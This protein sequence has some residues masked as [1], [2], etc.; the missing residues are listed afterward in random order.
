MAV[1][2]RLPAQLVR[3]DPPW[4]NFA[5]TIG[6]L[7]DLLVAAKAV[8]PA[9]A[10]QAVAAVLGREAEGSTALLDIRIGI[11]HGR[12]A[13]LSHSLLALAISPAG[14][15]EAVP[16]V[17]IQIV[18]L[19]LSPPAATDEHLETLAEIATLLR[20]DDLRACLLAV[21]DA[22]AALAMLRRHARTL[23]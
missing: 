2:D 13:G 7:V 20:S 3:I 21:P 4:R 9:H 6:G 8:S 14:L 5:D 23:P 1:L 19:V 11:P 16:T 10:P 18:A 17:G 22:P 15:Y 12:L